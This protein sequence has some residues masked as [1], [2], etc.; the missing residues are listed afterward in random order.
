M[1]NIKSG[2][3]FAPEPKRPAFPPCHGWTCAR[4][5]APRAWDESS[6]VPCILC[7]TKEPP[8]KGEAGS[9]TLEICVPGGTEK[10]ILTFR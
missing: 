8:V 7:S 6:R 10:W 2:I 5:G 3:G 1:R 4:R 9:I